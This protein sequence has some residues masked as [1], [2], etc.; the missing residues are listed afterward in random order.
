MKLLITHDSMFLSWM[1]LTEGPLPLMSCYMRLG[2]GSTDA[3][4]AACLCTL[5]GDDPRQLIPQSYPPQAR[6]IIAVACD[7]VGKQK[8]SEVVAVWTRKKR[9]I[10][11]GVPIAIHRD[12]EF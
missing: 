4:E 1:W 8:L 7:I 6:F 11:L 5:S 9:E 12:T 10:V 3:R 2:S